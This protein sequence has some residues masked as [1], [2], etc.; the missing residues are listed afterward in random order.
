M[1]F[2]QTPKRRVTLSLGMVFALFVTWT[3][4]AEEYVEEVVVTGS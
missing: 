4:T 1:T 2:R 3:A